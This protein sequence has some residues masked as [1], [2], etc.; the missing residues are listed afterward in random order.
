MSK[1]P[2]PKFKARAVTYMACEAGNQSGEHG[3]PISIL[4]LAEQASGDVF[5]VFL[6]MDDTRR[7]A[8]SLLV[9]LWTNDD[10]FAEQVLAAHFPH[11]EEGRYYWPTRRRNSG[12]KWG[13]D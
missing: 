3:E 6:T 12:G 13:A 4:T 9:A 5:P 1:K 2:R 7:L 10:D 8:A 11:D